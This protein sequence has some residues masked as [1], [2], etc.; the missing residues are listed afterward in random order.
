LFFGVWWEVFDE[1]LDGTTHGEFQTE[2][3]NGNAWLSPSRAHLGFLDLFKPS[4]IIFQ[5]FIILL[6][7]LYSVPQRAMRERGGRYGLFEKVRGRRHVVGFGTDE[8]ADIP[9]R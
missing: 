1:F 8:R 9:F 2:V 7:C 5:L 6:Y 3:P 4:N